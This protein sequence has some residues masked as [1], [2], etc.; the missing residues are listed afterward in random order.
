[1]LHTPISPS[2]HP[3]H[4]NPISAMRAC[5]SGREA[6]PAADSSSSTRCRRS[7][8]TAARR[9]PTAWQK[10]QD[11]SFLE[12][13]FATELCSA[14]V[15]DAPSD[16]PH[17]DSSCTRKQANASW[18]NSGTLRTC[19]D[20]ACQVLRLL[21]RAKLA[22]HTVEHK[23]VGHRACRAGATCTRSARLPLHTLLGRQTA[24]L[25]LAQAMYI[26]SQVTLQSTGICIY[27]PSSVA[28]SPIS[29]RL[30][31]SV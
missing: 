3:A 6:S 4:L 7:S 28:R 18:R 16:K 9:T 10:G 14:A 1:M 21:R 27:S 29:P 30:C 25:N 24:A 2:Q 20:Q 8:G 11:K 5:H 22:V 26:Y 15:S 31:S 23:L 12:H 17:L 13:T 19:T